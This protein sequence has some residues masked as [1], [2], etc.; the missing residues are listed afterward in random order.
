MM[1][2][3]FSQTINRLV[4]FTG[5]FKIT[6]GAFSGQSGFTNTELSEDLTDDSPNLNPESVCL[7]SACDDEVDFPYTNPPV[8]LVFLQQVP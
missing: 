7:T 2:I 3:E 8:V 4:I 6:P 5:G 1:T